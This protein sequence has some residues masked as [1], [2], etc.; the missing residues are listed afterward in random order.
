MQNVGMLPY[1]GSTFKLENENTIVRSTSQPHTPAHSRSQSS[2][3]PKQFLPPDALAHQAIANSAAAA[4]GTQI[5]QHALPQRPMSAQELAT[6]YWRKA[7]MSTPVAGDKTQAV[8]DA[9]VGATK[10]A[11][12]VKSNGILPPPS[13]HVPDQDKK[14]YCTYWIRTGECD[15]TQQ[16]CLHKHEMPEQDTL[17]AIGFRGT[18][19]WWIEKYS[20]VRMGSVKP[21]S[22]RAMNMPSWWPGQSSTMIKA[23]SNDSTDGSGSETGSDHSEPKEARKVKRTVVQPSA[24][25][26]SS[27]TPPPETSKVDHRAGSDDSGDLIDFDIITTPSTSPSASLEETPST[28]VETG[29]RTPDMKNLTETKRISKAT[30]PQRVFV[31]ASES[32][33]AHIAQVRMRNIRPQAP[34]SRS[35]V[36]SLQKQIQSLQ[37]SKY[38]SLMASKHVATASGDSSPKEPQQ[39]GRKRVPKCDRAIPIRSP[40]TCC[41]ELA[42]C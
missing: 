10:G 32:P 14:E 34:P 4:G 25:M 23:E 39:L 33:E 3:P 28:P 35:E 11:D 8:I 2:S 37:K 36:P 30:S 1:T 7:P 27:T 5:P 42:G 22:S 18:P 38:G 26:A 15:Y 19:R 29:K 31:P 40:C 6:T 9:I 20:K 21:P 13:E 12:A 16:G 24:P 41:G 17:K